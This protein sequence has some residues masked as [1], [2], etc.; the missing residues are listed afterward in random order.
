MFYYH[1]ARNQY[2]LARVINNDAGQREP[3]DKILK[4]EAKNTKV[5][6]K[7]INYLPHP[8]EKMGILSFFHNA[9]DLTIYGISSHPISVVRL[10]S[11]S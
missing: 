9:S 7:P 5:P 6:K 4:N 2:A 1:R 11:L 10:I 3:R 8:I